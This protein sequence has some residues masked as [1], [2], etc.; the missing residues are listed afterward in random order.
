[1]K[2]VDKEN[3]CAIAQIVI[4]ERGKTF[5][6]IFEYKIPEHLR[7]SAR[8]GRIAQ[9]PFGRQNTKREG[10]IFALKETPD[11]DIELKSVLEI[12]EKAGDVTETQ[13]KIC[14]FMREEY[15]C[16]YAEAFACIVP[17]FAKK[18]GKEQYKKTLR[19]SGIYE[20]KEEYFEQIRPGAKAQRTILELLEEQAADYNTMMKAGS[21]SPSAIKAL[22]E[23][24]LIVVEKTEFYE[25]HY[26]KIQ[27]EDTS[28]PP[29]LAQQ[30]KVLEE[31]SHSDQNK[32]LLHGITGSGKTEAYLN[33][34]E[35]C[36]KSGKQA[37]YLLPEIALTAQTVQRIAKRFGSCAVVH[38]RLAEGERYYQYKRIAS[39][40]AKVILGARS[41]LFYP[42][43]NLGLIILD[44][45]HEESYK[46]T[47]TPRYDSIEV[48]EFI[49]NE[50]DC[51]L[52]LGSATP[53]VESYYYAKRGRYQMLK[54][55]NR[56]FDLALP[57]IVVSDM[58][59]E[60]QQG[61]RSMLSSQLEESIRS[62]LEKKEQVILF[63]NRRG[64]ST[65]VFCRS[66]GYS[67]RCVN[68][69]VA[70]TYHHD[71]QKMMCHYCGYEKKV[72]VFC[73]SCGSDKIRHIGM[74]TQKIETEIEQKFPYAKI[75]RM[76]K[77]TTS[78]KY[79][80]D[81]ITHQF[82]NHE[83]DI[84]IGTQ[85]VVKGFDFPL[86]SV[87]GVILADMA[88]NMP[89]IY[90]SFRAFCLAYQAA[91]RCGRKSGGGKVFIQTYSP[92]HYVIERVKEYD[93]E[94]FYKDE[95]RYRKKMSYP[96]YCAL[97][98]FYFLD[99][100]EQKAEEAAYAFAEKMIEAI[101]EEPCGVFKLYHPSKP[102]LGYV[103]NK[104]I[105]HVI[106]KTSGEKN[107]KKAMKTVYNTIAH[108]KNIMAYMQK[109][110]SGV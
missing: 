48:A 9:V 24:G 105:Y 7:A 94:G 91:G 85:M 95:I 39:G 88:L 67:E 107:V 61:N 68:C 86:V 54:M 87:V 83:A 78:T 42:Y 40:E 44:E 19:L 34:I 46:S 65:Y 109:N 1:M 33:M 30:K 35:S 11:T 47:S 106:I 62:A 22:E 26:Q 15:F 13:V 31:Y 2:N 75:I 16:T 72:E 99:E 96:P 37:L 57:D 84:L 38:S 69:D 43:K 41:A 92:E 25:A 45:C 104:H 50:S 71:T 74:G 97:Y 32:F 51:K 56:I 64:M 103:N 60:L 5:D 18:K 58:R 49:A 73:P 52:V 101:K 10:F 110:P 12:Y 20:T 23:K 108:E 6:R 100:N 36:V 3:A 81:N 55:P 53:L 80:F 93:Y 21:F 90:S 79:A 77:D 8:I 17:K 29:L 14:A 66:C 70:L 28:R 89:D 63:L 4:N 102:V 59:Q 82:Q 76:D 27:E 98:G